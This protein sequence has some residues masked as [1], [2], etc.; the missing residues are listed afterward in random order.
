MLRAV[1]EPGDGTTTDADLLARFDHEQDAAAFE[2]LVWRHGGMVYQTAR[3]ILHDH[4]LAE[5]VTQAVFLLLAR[6]AGRLRNTSAVVGWLHTCTHRLA[7]RHAQHRRPVTPLPPEAAAREPND[8]SWQKIVAEEVARLPEKYRLPVLLCFY[9]GL[10]HADAAARLGRPVGTIAGWMARAKDRLQ[11]RLVARGV[12]LAIITGTLAVG[13]SPPLSAQTVH[14]ITT[15]SLSWL[16]GAAS[17]PPVLHTLV[18]GALHD[19]VLQKVK[20]VAVLGGLISSTTVG[21]LA[22]VHAQS[23]GSGSATPVQLPVPVPATAQVPLAKPIPVSPPAANAEKPRPR[24]LTAQQSTASTNSLKQIILGFYNYHDT[25][26]FYPSDIIDAKTKKPLLSWRVA[27]L[28]FIEQDNLYREFK[29]DEPWD[30][31]HN[32]PL[33][34]KMPKA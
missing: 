1:L 21:T 29:L 7:L 2:L 16:S 9:E 28:P 11:T 12:P 26:S 23:G 32:L 19:M 5:D 10:S 22:Y 30:S 34:K 4:H 25:F 31:A 6:K 17:L 33:L 20:L 8:D 18:H 27:I 3:S 13:T 24:K 15:L 14:S